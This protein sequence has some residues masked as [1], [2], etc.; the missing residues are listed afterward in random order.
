MILFVSTLICPYSTY[1]LIYIKPMLPQ[2]TADGGKRVGP[3][4]GLAPIGH[5]KGRQSNTLLIKRDLTDK[6]S[7]PSQ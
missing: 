3:L 7:M 4:T 2:C 1:Q 5:A 6:L